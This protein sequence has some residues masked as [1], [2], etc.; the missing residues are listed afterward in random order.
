MRPK[1]TKAK[2]KK[3]DET[4]DKLHLKEVMPIISKNS[5]K[6]LIQDEINSLILE[7]IDNEA[8]HKHNVKHWRERKINLKIGIRPDYIN[9]LAR[10]TMQCNNQ[11]QSIYALRENQPQ[12]IKWVKLSLQIL[13]RNWRNPRTYPPNL[14][15][16]RKKGHKNKVQRCVQR[17]SQ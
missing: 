12:K 9:K 10:K 13:L 8:E 11:D 4:I 17:R 7:E 2:R 5:L 16:G 6:C 1:Q 15:K 3:I 14:P